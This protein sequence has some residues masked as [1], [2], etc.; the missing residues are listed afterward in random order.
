MSLEDVTRVPRRWK[1]DDSVPRMPLAKLL[2]QA[3]QAAASAPDR[4]DL[5]VRLA[6]ALFDAG[7]TAELIALLRPQLADE[8]AA[9]DLLYWLVHVALKVIKHNARILMIFPRLSSGNSRS[10]A[11][12]ILSPVMKPGR[13]LW[14]AM[15][16]RQPDVLTFITW[17]RKRR[18][19][20]AHVLA[21]Q[22]WT[23][24][25]R[26]SSARV[27]SPSFPAPRAL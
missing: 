26:T 11:S 12:H 9:P 13:G 6:A 24:A 2:T 8:H 19:L 16:G 17:E 7:H 18:S 22:P 3:R 25:Y 21:N 10:I 20:A 4:V 5:K 1:D 15:K 27:F 23:E 14:L